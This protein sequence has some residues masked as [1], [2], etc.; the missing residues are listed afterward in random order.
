MNSVSWSSWQPPETITGINDP[1][2]LSLAAEVGARLRE[3]ALF[4]ATAESC[5]GG[6]LSWLITTVPGS[7]EWFDRGFI[8]YQN[9]AKQDMLGVSETVLQEHGVVSEPTAMAMAEGACARSR[10]QI[11]VAI[12][13]IAG[14]DGGSADK[15]VG[16]VCFA[17]HRRGLPTMTRRFVFSGDREVTR[18]LSCYTALTGLLLIPALLSPAS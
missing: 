13:G 9:R 4:V 16:T 2:L 11:G 12:T 5:T 10:A 17:W 15:P 1:E 6:G 3:T 8:V 18:S 14:P 7:S